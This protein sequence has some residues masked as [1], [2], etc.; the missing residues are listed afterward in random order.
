MRQLFARDMTSLEAIFS[1]LRKFRESEKIAD[2]SGY[3]IDVAVEEFFTNIVKYGRGGT[4]DIALDVRKEERTVTVSIEEHTTQPFDV[5]RPTQTQFDL[6]PMQRRPGGLGVHL[7]K[8]M[9]DGLVY[10]F[11]GDVSRIVMK[12]QLEM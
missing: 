1:F 5:T 10:E 12:K 2:S 7:A 11:D 8:E 4:G 6:P 9:L 3:A